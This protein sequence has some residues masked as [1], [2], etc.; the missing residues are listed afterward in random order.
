LNRRAIFGY[1][2]PMATTT[3]LVRQDQLGTARI[4]IA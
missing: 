4:A 1:R 2:A 3:F